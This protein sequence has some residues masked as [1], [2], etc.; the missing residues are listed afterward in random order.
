MQPLFRAPDVRRLLVWLRM[1]GLVCC[2]AACEREYPLEP[3]FCDRWC[4]TFSELDCIY[5]PTDCVRECEDTKGPS[6]CEGVSETLLACYQD[7]PADKFECFSGGDLASVRVADGACQSQRDELY[8]CAFPGIGQCL[9]TCRSL[10][11]ELDPEE[12]ANCALGDTSCEE[13][14]WFLVQSGSNL[15]DASVTSSDDVVPLLLSSVLCASDGDAGGPS[16]SPW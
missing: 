4:H 5:S 1:F 2:F 12:L 9:T 3:T 10:Q 15:V 6:A 8:E 16:S 11:G 14:C 13:M 7:T